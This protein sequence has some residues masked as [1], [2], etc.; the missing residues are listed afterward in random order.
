M[1]L[2]GVHLHNNVYMETRVVINWGQEIVATCFESI[3]VKK[4]Q[5]ISQVLHQQCGN[6]VPSS[7]TFAQWSRIM[8]DSEDDLTQVV[9]TQWRVK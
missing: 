3:K 5:T 9:T 7:F 6:I 4:T 8:R 2:Y 1:I